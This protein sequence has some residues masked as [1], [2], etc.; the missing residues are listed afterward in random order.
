MDLGGWIRQGRLRG[1][2]DLI[3][4]L[5]A[6]S[7]YW[8]AVALDEEVAEAILAEEDRRRDAHGDGDTA[9]AWTPP[10]D[11]W[12]LTAQ[13]LGALINEVK[14][15]RQATIAAAGGRARREK[16]FPGPRTAREAVQAR[17]DEE[18]AAA[19]AADFGF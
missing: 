12:D 16:P 14:A 8:S 9:P 11:Q 2:L 1:V 17:R 4:Q 5:P 13:M 19:L 15:L 3:D 18:Y 7:R 6:A 10:L